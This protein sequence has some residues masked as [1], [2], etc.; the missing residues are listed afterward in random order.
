MIFFFLGFLRTRFTTSTSTNKM[1]TCPLGIFHNLG[2]YVTGIIRGLFDRRK[3]IN[4]VLKVNINRHTEHFLYNYA[5]FCEG[6]AAL[7][8]SAMT[9]IQHGRR[10]EADAFVP[11]CLIILHTRHNFWSINSGV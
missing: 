11:T 5:A 3:I 10:T 6:R 1:A 9:D 4:Y 7:M 8:R 2:S